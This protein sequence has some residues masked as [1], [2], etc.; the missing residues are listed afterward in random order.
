MPFRSDFGRIADVYV[1]FRPAYPD[2][3]F[4]RI[5]AVVPPERRH[6]A[7]D[8]GAGTGKS[9]RPL[10][11]HFDELIAVE[12]DQ[13]MAERLR[14]SDPRIIL[15]IVSAEECEQEPASVDLV[16][17][18]SALHWMDIPRLMA[19]A[20][21]WLRTSGIL[22][23]WA[24]G[25]PPAPEPVDAITLQE[26]VNHWNR[27]RD[28]RNHLAQSSD[29]VRRAS[30]GFTILEER[31]IPNVIWLTPHEFVGFWRSTSSASAYAR[32]LAFPEAYWRDLE[33]RYS[34]AWPRAK[35]PVDFSPWLLLARKD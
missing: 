22:A 32:K 27:F 23:V 26:L 13:L 18:G 2:E 5:L 33:T 31:I 16:A 7:M 19:N 17:S 25:I 29:H 35:I 12:P 9:I 34:L 6:R 8:L 20:L 24:G 14:A 30:A 15:Q 28:P 1:A 21:K 11:R 4:E 3:L 10:L